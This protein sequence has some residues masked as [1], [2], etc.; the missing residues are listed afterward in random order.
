MGTPQTAVFDTNLFVRVFLA[1]SAEARRCRRRLLKTFREVRCAVVLHELLR[2][3]NSRVG[4][5]DYRPQSRALSRYLA[6]SAVV[7]TPDLEDWKV[8]GYALQQLGNLDVVTL[9]K[10]TNDALIA[11]LCAR[12]D[13]FLVTADNDFRKLAKVRSLKGLRLLPWEELSPRLRLP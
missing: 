6:A 9:R 8:A 12:K 7:E 5:Q 10:M 2:G 13:Y 11:A 1:Q 3:D 4:R